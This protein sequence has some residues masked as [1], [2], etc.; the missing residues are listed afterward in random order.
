MKRLMIFLMILVASVWMGIVVMKHPG[1]VM[2]IAKPWMVQMP[3][4]FAGIVLA[5]LIVIFYLVIDSI[6]RVQ[7]LWFSLKNWWRFR[8]EHQLYNKTQHGLTL[9]IEGRWQKAERLLLAGIHQSVDP[10]MNYLG[11]AKAAQ[12][13]G[14]DDRR[15]DYIKKAYQV[16]PHAK[17]AIGLAQAELEFAHEQFKQAEITLNE[18]RKTA[19]RHPRVIKLLEKVY[20][21]LAEWQHLLELIPSLRKAKVVTQEQASQFE[22]H[23][24]CEIFHA[25][26]AHTLTEIEHLWNEVPRYLRKDPDLIYAFAKQRIQ[27]PDTKEVEE[28]IRKA[29]KHHWHPGL[30]TIYGTLSFTNLNRQLVIVGAWLKIY[31]PKPELLLA[32]GRLCVQVQ[33]WG[34]AKDYFEKCLSLGPNSEATLAY[35]Q[36]LEQLGEP[37]AALK[38]YRDGVRA[39][40]HA[41]SIER[42]YSCAVIPREGAGPSVA[43]W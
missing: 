1:F 29:L 12:E 26:H 13:L 39:A 16:A 3:L 7:F 33:L 37:E 20:V 10:L 8:R 6:D 35:G 14:A 30:A 36:L 19:P 2:I 27:F 23:V 43:K 9:L 18:L 42:Q 21:R 24:Y 17:L 11:A 31:G 40:A 4:W 34:K 15:D 32:L 38:Q 28:L 5:L 25:S 41:G 22:K